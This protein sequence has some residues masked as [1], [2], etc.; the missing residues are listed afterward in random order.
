MKQ[1]IIP[2]SRIVGGGICVSASDGQKVYAKVREA[3]VARDAVILS[4]SGVSR[5]TTA[6]LNAAVGQL[7]GEFTEDVIRQRLAPPQDYEPWHLS[8]LKMVVDR[9][10]DY[11]NDKDIVEK[12]FEQNTS[13]H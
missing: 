4:F 9:A 8:R 11:F 13:R 2:I 10:K 3:V 7:Y 1:T 6:F 12:A 5:M